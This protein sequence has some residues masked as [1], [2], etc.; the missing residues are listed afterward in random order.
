MRASWILLP[1]SLAL[2]LALSCGPES[3]TPGSQDDG[4]AGGGES[5]AGPSDVEDGQ[6]GEQG[7]SWGRGGAADPPAEAPDDPVDEPGEDEVPGEEEDPA[8]PD[9]PGEE[10]DPEGPE[11]PVEEPEPDVEC[12]LGSKWPER[13]TINPDDPEYEDEEFTNEEVRRI[14]AQGKAENSAAYRAYKIAYDNQ[15][16]LECAFC[17][18]GCERSIGHRSN[19]DCFKDMHGFW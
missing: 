17:A 4:P 18:C 8:D 10:E 6:P 11:E 13:G 14:F 19:V 3:R 12:P 7:D 1:A 9:D 16:V 2:A 15:A 5:P